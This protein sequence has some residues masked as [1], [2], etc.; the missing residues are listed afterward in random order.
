L[1][2][3][4]ALCCRAL[5]LPAVLLPLYYSLVALSALGLGAVFDHGVAAI[6]LAG[7]LLMLG[8]YRVGR[9]GDR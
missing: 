6:H 3:A 4:A 1:F 2:F 9:P 7:V 5:L 8:L